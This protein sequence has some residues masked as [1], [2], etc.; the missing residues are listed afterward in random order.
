MLSKEQHI[1]YWKKSGQES[2]ETAMFLLAGKRNVDAL[3]MFDLAIEKWLKGNWVLDNQ[4]NYPP[5]I[6][7]LQS[8][9]NQTDLDV[10]AD[11]ID[12]L[13]TVNRWNIE[14]RYPDYKFSL[15]AQATD[16]YLG[17]QL[18]KLKIIKLINRNLDLLIL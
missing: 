16:E 14:V 2:W 6:H 17:Q 3:F 15:H 13:D 1:E 8:L 7:D 12:F 18:E 11:L 4:N 9:K 5:R 10:P